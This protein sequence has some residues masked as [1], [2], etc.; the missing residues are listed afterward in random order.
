VSFYISSTMNAP[1]FIT[2]HKQYKPIIIVTYKIKSRADNRKL[3]QIT[4]GIT[5]QE[6]GSTSTV[7]FLNGAVC[8]LL[9]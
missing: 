4:V 6:V 3:L 5:L 1:S 2:T 9:T 8:A 7:I